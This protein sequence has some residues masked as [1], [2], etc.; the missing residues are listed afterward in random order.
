MM[1]IPGKDQCSA[2]NPYVRIFGNYVDVLA[3]NN[4]DVNVRVFRNISYP[5]THIL[6]ETQT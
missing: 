5:S 4:G 6:Q 3:Q 1:K 2:E